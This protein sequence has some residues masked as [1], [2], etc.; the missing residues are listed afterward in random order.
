MP[1][2]LVPAQMFDHEL[3]PTKGWPSPYAVDK[4]ATAATGVTAIF[5]GTGVSLDPSTNQLV[6]GFATAGAMAMFAFQ[7]QDDFDVNGDVGNII[8][9]NINCLVACGAYE[10]ETTEY[11]GSD[12]PPQLPLTLNPSTGKVV[13]ASG[14]ISGTDDVAGVVSD[15]GPI[16]NAYGKNVV[17]FWPVYCPSRA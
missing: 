3:N 9:N 14:G 6:L 7:N 16:L 17:R 15:H 10:L 5:A 8:G 12:F 2:T 13:A 4:A 1:G 11:E